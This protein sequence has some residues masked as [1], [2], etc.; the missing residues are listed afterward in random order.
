M[1]NRMNLRC[2]VLVQDR[3]N[4]NTTSNQQLKPLA[5]YRNFCFLALV[6]R[7]GLLK[8]AITIRLSTSSVVLTTYKTRPPF[9]RSN[10]NHPFIHVIRCTHDL[11]TR[12][13]LLKEALKI[14]LSTSS[15]VL[16]TYLLT[17]HDALL[18][19]AITIRLS[20]SSVV[21]TTY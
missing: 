5:W 18:K 10:N 13:G 19:E 15:V 7:H 2:V 4:L 9:E 8:E 20:T 6:T 12:H 3:S 16:T 1:N 14:P 11:L 17:R 21:L